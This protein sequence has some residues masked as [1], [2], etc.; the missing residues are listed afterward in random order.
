MKKHYFLLLLLLMFVNLQAQDSRSGLDLTKG[1]V[2]KCLVD[3][4]KSDGW[5]LIKA[6]YD[7]KGKLVLIFVKDGQT[8]TYISR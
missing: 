7:P 8:R 3:T 2:L 1:D 4:A 5:H 6:Y